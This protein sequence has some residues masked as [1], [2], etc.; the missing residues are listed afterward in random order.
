[1]LEIVQNATTIYF[2]SKDIDKGI[3]R[4]MLSEIEKYLTENWREAGAVYF[5]NSDTGYYIWVS[6]R[7]WSKQEV[8]T[9]INKL[10]EITSSI[11]IEIS[12]ESIERAE[13]SNITEQ[14]TDVIKFPYEV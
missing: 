7:Q 2:R 3:T 14:F 4:R 1:M 12:I 9:I 10:Y 11:D 6:N 5:R 8:I 13:I